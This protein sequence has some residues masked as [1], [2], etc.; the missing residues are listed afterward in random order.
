MSMKGQTG[1]EY[2]IMI[3][4]VLLVALVIGAYM[5][6][7]ASKIYNEVT[8]V[9]GATLKVNPVPSKL[10]YW[11][12][13]NT[14]GSASFLTVNDTAGTLTAN[15]KIIANDFCT[16][17]GT[18]LSTVSGGGGGTD[19]RCDTAGTCSQLCIGSDCITSWS[20]VNY[21]SGGGG[22]ISCASCDS[23]FVKKAG[24]T[25][26]ATFTFSQPTIYDPAIVIEQTDTSGTH[27]P[28]ELY[29]PSATTYKHIYINSNS[30]QGS[31]AVW[32]KNESTG[33]TQAVVSISP[34]GI[35]AFA[36]TTIQGKLSANKLCINKGSYDDCISDW[37]D[38]NENTTVTIPIRCQYWRQ[39]VSTG[40]TW[41]WQYN[42]KYGCTAPP[43][44]PSGW[45][46]VATGTVTTDAYSADDTV[47]Y[48]ETWCCR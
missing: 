19:T 37:S 38:I 44:C 15:G 24:D 28:L 27:F 2:L 1:V 25:L 16:P 20:E 10:A 9:S 32:F 31:L 36:D 40:S 3:G 7:A 46:K 6:T 35:D 42:T 33:A 13:E 34:T 17:T 12:D 21:V 30:N 39:W 8:G 5:T 47:G 4:G 29:V 41:Q 11:V 18:C 48:F 22:S 14:L 45:T 43:S 26:S 23:R